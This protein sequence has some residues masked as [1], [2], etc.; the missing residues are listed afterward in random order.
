MVEQAAA[1]GIE[2]GMDDR[3][4]DGV[5]RLSLRQGSGEVDVGGDDE[6]EV[7]VSCYMSDDRSFSSVLTDHCVMALRPC[8]RSLP[9]PFLTTSAQ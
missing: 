7:P 6:A 9:R 3:D 4:H 8:F 2:R 1:D 5:L